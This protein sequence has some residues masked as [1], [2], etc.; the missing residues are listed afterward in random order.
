MKSIEASSIPL[1][2]KVYL[3]K[4]RLGWR[5]IHPIR[6]EDGTINGFNFIFGSKSNLIFLIILLLLCVGFYLGVNELIDS[7]RVIANNPCKFCEDCFSAGI[8]SNW[9]SIN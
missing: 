4:D 1:E 3:S 2:E 6:N 9:T 5:V 8:N 7:Y